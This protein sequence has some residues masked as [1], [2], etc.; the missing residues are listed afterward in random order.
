MAGGAAAYDRRRTLPRLIGLDPRELDGDSAALDRRI[1]TRL[2][3]ALRA[4]RRRGA[5]GHWTY[6]VSRHLALAQ[7]IAGEAV[8]ATQRRK[9]D[10]APAQDAERE[11]SG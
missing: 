5:A 7:A 6:D 1:R 3:R 10:P 8:R 11:T 4:E 9:V 2:A